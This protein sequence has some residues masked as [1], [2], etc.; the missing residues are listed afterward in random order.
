MARVGARLPDM[1]LVERHQV[2]A[3]AYGRMQ[4]DGAIRTVI[5]GLALP[6]DV[7]D[8]PAVRRAVLQRSVPTGCQVTGL[9]VLWA[10]GYAPVPAALDVRTAPG[11][12]VRNWRETMPLV[13]HGVGI[14]IGTDGRVA[15]TGLATAM[16][17][18][19]RWAPLELAVP[20]VLRAFSDQPGQ[21]RA[22]LRASVAAGLDS[23]MRGQSAWATVRGVLEGGGEPHLGDLSV[24]DAG[25]A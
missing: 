13:F 1:W 3:I 20:A 10:L 7:P 9:G 14:L 19:L 23:D 21:T 4:R 5:P 17:D 22:G 25:A 11:R 8:S 18:A 12:H 16:A 24:R 15:F 6:Q 2:G